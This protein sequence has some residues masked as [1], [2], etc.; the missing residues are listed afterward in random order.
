MFCA[1]MQ[2]INLKVLEFSI[3]FTYISVSGLMHAQEISA[4]RF[5]ELCLIVVVSEASFYFT[6]TP[7]FLKTLLTTFFFTPFA[8]HTRHFSCV[9]FTNQDWPNFVECCSSLPTCASISSISFARRN[10]KSLHHIFLLR[11]GEGKGKAVPLQAWTGP[12]GSRKLK[13]RDFVTTAQD[14]RKVVRHTH[15]PPLHSENT[16][17]THFC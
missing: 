12:E 4:W 14:G 5:V 2:E 3:Y 15:R 13:F 16:P 11:Q 6:R 1:Y 9:A 17:G 7:Y 8:V 10:W